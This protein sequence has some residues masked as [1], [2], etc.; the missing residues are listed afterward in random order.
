MPPAHSVSIRLL[1]C[2]MLRVY[3]TPHPAPEQPTPAAPVPLAPPV[4]LLYGTP[5]TKGETTGRLP[6][7]LMNQ[8]MVPNGSTGVPYTVS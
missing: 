6:D 7:G 4:T 8:R 2:P 1:W 5:N 3:R